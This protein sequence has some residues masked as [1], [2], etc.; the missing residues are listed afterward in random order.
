[1]KKIFALVLAVTMVLSMAACAPAANDGTTTAGTTEAQGPVTALEV[2][3]AVWN[4]Y[5][6]EDKFAVV[7][8]SV[9]PDSGEAVSMEGPGD[10]NMAQAEDL[11]YSLLIPAEQLASVDEAATMVHMMNANTFTGGV[12]HLAADTDM[13]AFASAVRDSI[14]GNQWMCGFPERMVIASLGNNYVLI[15][16]GVGDAMNPFCEKLAAAYESA[17]MLY[18]EAIG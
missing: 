6:D 17:S 7:G 10:Y 12:V 16:Y 5:A 4:Q 15:A 9:D 18:D 1:M 3:E 13:A 14:Q 8:G 2:L 11:S